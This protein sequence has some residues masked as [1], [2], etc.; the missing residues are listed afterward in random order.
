MFVNTCGTVAGDMV[1]FQTTS[2]VCLGCP[3][4]PLLFRLFF[5]RVVEHVRATMHPGD[6]VTI[7]NVAMWAALYANNVVL[8]SPTTP[9]LTR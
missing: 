6:A 7:A 3:L 2:G 4:S 1:T 8:L 5:D 9:G